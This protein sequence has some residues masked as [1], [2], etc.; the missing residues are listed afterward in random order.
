MSDFSRP[1]YASYVA[2][3]R[4]LA[5]ARII[6]FGDWYELA[7]AVSCSVENWEGHSTNE[8]LVWLPSL[9]DWLEM[10]ETVSVRA[11][12]LRY[13]TSDVGG[14]DGFPQ[15]FLLTGTPSSLRQAGPGQPW[16][17]QPTRTVDAPTREEAA[18]RLWMAVAVPKD[19]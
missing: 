12:E 2:L 5:L 11:I 8:A 15:G 13:W 18:A 3:C 9:S 16:L 10:L 19:A 1:E 17:P 14:P 6:R 4:E 7:G